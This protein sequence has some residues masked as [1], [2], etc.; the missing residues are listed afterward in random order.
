MDYASPIQTFAPESGP[1]NMFYNGYVDRTPFEM[2]DMSGRIERFNPF[3]NSADYHSGTKNGFSDYQRAS[4]SSSG[5]EPYGSSFHMI[6]AATH[7]DFV[8]SQ[9]MTYLTLLHEHTLLSERQLA[10]QASIA[11]LSQSVPDA[12]KNAPMQG[13]SSSAILAAGSTDLGE[14]KDFPKI[15]FWTRAKYTKSCATKKTTTLNDEP[16]KRGNTRVAQDIN[17]MHRYIENADGS[18]ASGKEAEAMRKTQLAIFQEIK[19]TS[20][21]DVP[22]TWGAASL[23]VQNYHRAQM[24]EAHPCLRLCKSHWKVDYM[25]TLTYSSWYIKMT[26]KVSRSIP[27]TR[28]DDCVCIC[29]CSADSPDAQADDAADDSRHTSSSPPPLD[30]RSKSGAK[31]KRA[32]FLPSA[33]T[34]RPRL[35]TPS[36]ASPPTLPST[37]S[38]EPVDPAPLTVPAPSTS[39]TD[40]PAALST[41]PPSRTSEEIIEPAPLTVPDAPHSPLIPPFHS[42]ADPSQAL[43]ETPPEELTGPHAAR[44]STPIPHSPLCSNDPLADTPLASH[45]SADPDLDDNTTPITPESRRPNSGSTI[46]GTAPIILAAKMIN[47]LDAAFGAAS[48]PPK[49][50]DGVASQSESSTAKTANNKKRANKTSTS[51]ANLFYIDYLKTNKPITTNEFDAMFKALPA[52]DLKKWTDMSQQLGGA[53][54]KA[55]KAAATASA[56]TW[57]ALFPFLPEDTDDFIPDSLFFNR[58]VFPEW[59]R[60]P[61]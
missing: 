26:K 50:I 27:S 11:I 47:P 9:N 25:A 60:A 22:K 32:V 36:T 42:P 6:A 28:S 55:K 41:I 35:S 20:P 10:L 59:N 40:L 16:A 38:E 31:R 18:I 8:Q 5:A 21:H 53:K 30:A 58:T 52:T 54:R 7:E 57:S 33:L 39:S 19:R 15:R 34:K 24:Y 3:A 44:T 48:G 14:P 49:R 23:T 4:S 61:V 17:V 46:S 12:F 13:A 51:A 2:Y 43:P 29:T 1:S 37:P 56:S 45:F